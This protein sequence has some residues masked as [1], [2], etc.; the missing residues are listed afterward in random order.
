MGSIKMVLM[1]QFAGQQ[2][3]LTWRASPE[4]QVVKI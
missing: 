1:T 4:A 3:R 2:W